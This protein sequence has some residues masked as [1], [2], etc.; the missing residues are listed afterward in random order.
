VSIRLVSQSEATSI[1]A[2]QLRR[3]IREKTARVT[4]IGLGYVGLPF[5]RTAF[6]AGYACTGFDTDPRK[7]ELLRRGEGYLQ[8][9]GPDLARPFPGSD[10]F[11][12]TSESSEILCSDVFVVCVPTPLGKHQ[13][14]DLSYVLSS[15]KT[16]S[17]HLRTGSLVLLTSTTYPGTT[18]DEVLPLLQ[19]TGLTC[20][21]DFFLAFSPEREDPGRDGVTTSSIPRLVGGVDKLSGELGEEFLSNLVTEV[22]RVP[23]AEIAESAKLLENIYRAVNIALVNELK[24]L[25]A[26]LDIDI[27]QVIE[28]ASTK[29]F[30]FQPFF[31]GPGLGGHC[32][33]I[34][35]FYL[36]WRARE[37]G[38]HTRF[39][40]L[41]GEINTQMP[42]YVVARVSEALNDRGR[43]LRNAKILICGVAYKPNVQ[44]VRETP[45]AEI[46]ERL[47]A[48]GAEVC[49]HDPY[50]PTFPTMRRH[51][52]DLD[53]QP[54]SEELLREQDCVIV[55]TDHDGIDWTF[56]GENATLIV[57]TRNVMSLATSV[58]AQVV[59]A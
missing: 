42:G 16:I 33:P 28:A 59:K 52:I 29:P 23:S 30:G 11:S 31:P 40:E 15:V 50:I 39:I 7:I 19:K 51:A 18:R 22:H 32:I 35:P 48:R 58:K 44:D 10:R 53:S 43:P 46:I 57:D 38:L 54:L 1:P 17:K 6:D 26:E 21:R 49:Y 56:V 24:V 8:H 3:A 47:C 37:V 45:A 5:L 34:D 41:A 27:W 36:T 2:T 14:P 9:L 12:A 55:V 4:V 13:E 20:G 25:L